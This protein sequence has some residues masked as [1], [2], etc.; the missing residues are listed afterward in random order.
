MRFSPRIP[1]SA[2]TLAAGL[3]AAAGA[4]A[5]PQALGL[6]ATY[7]DVELKC[8]GGRCF[9]DFTAF[10]L[11]QDRKSPAR[12]TGY[13]LAN[14]D[15][16]LRATTADGKALTLDSR[17]HLRIESRRQHL[18]VRLS[19][20]REA[21]ADGVA[22]VAVNVK[23]GVVLLPESRT[24]DANPHT[25]GEVAALGARMRAI[26]TAAVDANPDRMAAARILTDVINGLPEHTPSDDLLRERLWDDAIGRRG[27][28]TPAKAIDRARGLYR[29]CRWMADRGTPTMRDC[30]EKHHDGLIKFLNG[31]YWKDS[32]PTM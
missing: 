13:F 10:C 28:A 22:A 18:A 9:A 5:A 32:R 6:V 21:L 26:G 19:V 2:I 29:L 7:G 20:P 4:H 8:E 23:K 1:V 14:G 17:R 12:G 27:G 3:M 16:A 11:Q 30:L 25:P 31:R 15:I 24:G